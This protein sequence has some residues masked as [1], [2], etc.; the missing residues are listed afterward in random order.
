M[1]SPPNPGVFIEEV[2]SRFKTIEGVRTSIAAFIGTAASGPVRQ[3]VKV[4]SL[5]DYEDSFGGLSASSEMSYAVRSFFAN[6]GLDAWIV[7]ISEDQR[8]IT[9][10]D[11]QILEGVKEP[12]NLLCLPGITDPSSLSTAARF[13]EM[14]RLF[15]IADTPK[16]ASI[17]EIQSAFSHSALPRT[18]FSA[19]Y[20]P[21][22]K[23]PDPLNANEPRIS[24]PAG[25]IAGLYARI[26]INRGVWKPPAGNEAC[27]K[28][29]TGLEHELADS[30]LTKLNSLGV[31][32]LRTIPG[33]G[34]VVWGARTMSTDPEWRYVNVRRLFIFIEDSIA[35]GTQW[36]VF[37]PNDEKLWK[38]IR[39]AVD[40]FLLNLF[41][42]GAFQGATA[43][44]AYYV[45]CGR[46]TMTQNDIDKGIVTIIVGVA[47]LKPAEF[48]VIKIAQLA[49]QSKG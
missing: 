45:K 40:S 24:A 15:L 33:A 1:P 18:S 23:I 28:D 22:L 16:G 38:A 29:I 44:Q 49:G 37:E 20:Y 25:A 31:N 48:V 5:R 46:D 39:T 7:R 30:E 42:S 41:Q 10:N 27:L 12:P 8:K 32:C 9:E 26:D 13:C 35:K 47:P 4:A 19:V 36:T 3:P 6:G 2:P 17:A 14:R 11:L 43:K 21:W 34:I